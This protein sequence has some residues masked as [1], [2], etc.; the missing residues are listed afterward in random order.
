MMSVYP[1]EAASMITDPSNQDARTSDTA[2][3]EEALGAALDAHANGELAAPFGVDEVALRVARRRA[4]RADIA[5]T[6]RDRSGGTQ[7]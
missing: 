4:T 5:R 1:G 3:V 7:I 6:L 2:L